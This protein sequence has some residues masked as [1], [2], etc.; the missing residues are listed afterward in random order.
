M[1]YTTYDIDGEP[2]RVAWHPTSGPLFVLTDIC[3]VLGYHLTYGTKLARDYSL[4]IHKQP[5]PTGQVTKHIDAEGLSSLLTH[6]PLRHNA[7]EMCQL[8]D[9]IIGRDPEADEAPEETP[10]V[11]GRKLRITIE[12]ELV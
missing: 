12:V 5:I 2:I 10:P 9:S 6:R 4:H 1:K 3:R 8:L 11:V 7:Y